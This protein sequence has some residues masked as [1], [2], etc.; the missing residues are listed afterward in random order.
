MAV[1]N[2]SQRD[3]VSAQENPKK[4]IHRPMFEGTGKGKVWTA[5]RAT[6]RR[7]LK[8]NPKNLL[9]DTKSVEGMPAMKFDTV[10]T[11]VVGFFGT[12]FAG[13]AAILGADAIATMAKANLAHPAYGPIRDGVRIFTEGIVGLKLVPWALGKYAK[14]EYGKAFWVGAT[15][16]TGLDLGITVA[17]YIAKSAEAVKNKA[18]PATTPAPAAQEAGMALVGLS[19]L[20]DLISGHAGVTKVSGVHTP[21]SA[22]SVETPLSIEGMDGAVSDEMVELQAAK[23]RFTELSSL[24]KG[25]DGLIQGGGSMMG[26]LLK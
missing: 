26:T 21:E 19:G 18:M 10:A 4:K 12:G 14:T 7:H 16:L 20:A 8:L 17:K 13:S 15:L 6:G 25:T 22:Q 1:E 24:L 3:I 9:P 11:G 23:A 5:K 2:F